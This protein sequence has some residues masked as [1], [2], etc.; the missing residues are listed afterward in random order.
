M[1]TFRYVLTPEDIVAFNAF[2]LQGRIDRRHTREIRIWF[3][4]LYGLLMLVELS[5]LNGVAAKWAFAALG[6]VG[7]LFLPALNR[8]GVVGR[9]RRLVTAEDSSRGSTGPREFT[10]SEAGVIESTAYGRHER[11]WC[12]V[13]ALKETSEH[14][15]VYIGARAAFIVPK[16][17][18]PDGGAALRASIEAHLPR[19][20]V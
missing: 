17:E 2:H 13:A 11:Y 19:G 16:R 10:V 15:F 5:R 3:A 20:D 7:V 8:Q 14:L 6:V 1:I 9:V 18:L 12:G 4:V